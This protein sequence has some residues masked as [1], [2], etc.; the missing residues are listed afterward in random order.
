M[1]HKSFDIRRAEMEDAGL[2]MVDPDDGMLV[3]VVHETSPFLDMAGGTLFARQGDSRGREAMTG[4]RKAGHL[5]T[6]VHGCD[7][8]E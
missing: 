2:V 6:S 1:Q 7:D 8:E 4:F 3:M 5:L